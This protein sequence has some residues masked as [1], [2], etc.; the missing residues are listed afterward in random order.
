MQFP[1]TA[2]AVPADPG[3]VTDP[4][5]VDAPFEEVTEAVLW[6]PDGWTAGEVGFVLVAGYAGARLRLVHAQVLDK[7]GVRSHV[8]L[9]DRDDV[10]RDEHGAVLLNNLG[11]LWFECPP[12]TR[13]V[14]VQYA[15]PGGLSYLAEFKPL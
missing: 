13:A 6:H 4:L 9:L 12:R 10:D 1:R 11:D 15:A 14:T 5:G 2:P 3:L 8:D 7:E